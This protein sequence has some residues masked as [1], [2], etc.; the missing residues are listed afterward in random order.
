MS[1]TNIIFDNKNAIN[2][3]FL[4]FLHEEDKFDEKA[5]SELYTYV[6]ELDSISLAELKDLYFISNQII[7]HIIYHFD[8]NDSTKITDLPSEYWEYID[9]IDKAINNIRSVVV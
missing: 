7:R 8:G 5:F 4:Y 6:S 9:S 3:S 2:Q 1:K